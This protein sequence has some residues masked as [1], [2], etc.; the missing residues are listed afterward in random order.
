MVGMRTP[1]AAGTAREVRAVVIGTGFA[2]IAMAVELRRLGI[3]DFVVLER[4]DDVGGTWRDNTY[5]GAACD[6]PSHLYSF[7]FA[8]NPDWT[9]S[10]SPQGEIH[11]YLRLV[12]HEHGV[13]DHCIF[14][15][16][17]VRAQWSDTDAR[18][19][20]ESTK[21]TFR[22]SLLIAGAGA[23][24]EPK[25]PDLPGLAS[26]EGRTFHSARWDHG[27]D[28]AGANVAVIGTGASAI[29]FVPQIAPSV[30]HLDVY[31]RTAPWVI[32][33][34]DR[35]FTRVER[36][37]F[38]HVPG[39]QRMARSA[40]YWARET[41][42]LGYLKGPRFSAPA[43]RIAASHLAKQVPDPNLRA[44]L[45]PSFRIGCK[46]VLISNDWYPALQRPNVDLVTD[47]IAEVRARTIVAQDGTERAADAIVFATGFHVTDAPIAELIHDGNGVPLSDA[48]AEGAQAY[49]GTTVSGY[50][51]LFFIVGPNTGLGHTSMVFMIESQVAY[52]S[53]AISRMDI[54][55]LA[56]VAPT[57]KAEQGYNERLQAQLTGTVWNSGG[58][59]S[60]YLDAHGRNTAIWPD[61]TFRFRSQTRRFDPEDYTVVTKAEASARK[62]ITA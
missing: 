41:F 22:S 50:P 14:G 8:P 62:R 27:Y 33:R 51:N 6:V 23:L 47:G 37:A 28:L 16:D 38:R 55:G 36:F 7:S 12:A 4:A 42:A 49:R 54:D 35:A 19:T 39:Y 1:E 44:R 17:V 20:V 25:D 11:A 46:R 9:R 45:T 18:W 53:D 5:P 61:F 34:R 32:P 13:Y 48:W 3:T 30:G 26:F 10:F 43:Q 52:I 58:C 59:Q 2:G 56:A 31:Q 57:P 15:A 60:W 40:I 21:G 29:Q 24:S